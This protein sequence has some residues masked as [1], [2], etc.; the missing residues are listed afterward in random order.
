MDIEILDNMEVEVTEWFKA[1]VAITTSTGAKVL[2]DC[3]RIYI[4]DDD[5][6]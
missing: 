5:G 2:H 3:E 6:E 4:Y 1:Y